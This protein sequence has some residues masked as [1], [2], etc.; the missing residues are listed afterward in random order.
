MP[1]PLV[2]VTVKV[3]GWPLARPVTVQDSGPLDQVQ[4][5]PS[6]LDVTVYPVMV[7]PFD[8]AAVQLTTAPASQGTPVTPV[9]LPGR[10][11]GTTALDG[12]DARPV[13][14]PLVAVTVKVYDWPLVRPLTVQEVVVPSGVVHVL[15]PGVLVTV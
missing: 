1:T 11:A 5:C 15:A 14:T 7:E 10:P 6:G 12:S 2:A 13:P 8:G 3:Y 4:V 9:G